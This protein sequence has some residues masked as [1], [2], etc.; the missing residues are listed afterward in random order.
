MSHVNNIS[1]IEGTALPI[2]P[3]PS[4]LLPPVTHISLTPE[5]SQ[6][7][8]TCPWNHADP[9]QNVLLLHRGEKKKKKIRTLKSRLPH[10]IDTREG[11]I[12]YLE[13]KAC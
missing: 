12:Y 7:T 9:R 8:A 1:T 11:G 10:L 13:T 2:F 5:E 3:L 6:D 4:N